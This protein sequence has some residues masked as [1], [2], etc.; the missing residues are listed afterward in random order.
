MRV[1]HKGEREAT[2]NENDEDDGD[3]DDDDDRQISAEFMVWQHQA[4]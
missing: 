4:R 1:W 2:R 3:D